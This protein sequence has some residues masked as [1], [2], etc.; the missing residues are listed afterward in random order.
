MID[1]NFRSRWVAVAV[2]SLLGACAA[3]APKP[4]PEPVKVTPQQPKAEPTPDPAKDYPSVFTPPSREDRTA[5]IER[6]F[7]REKQ[8]KAVHLSLVN[9]MLNQKNHYAALAHLDAYDSKWGADVNSKRLR[10]DALRK[11]G[12]LDEAERIYKQLLGK[13]DGGLVWYGL[14]RVS[15]DRG[16]LN[17]A[18]D[19]L[20]KSVKEDPLLTDAYSDLGLTYMLLNMQQSSYDAL[21]RAVQLSKNEPKSVANL[22]M[23]AIVNERYE[24]A[25]DLADRLEWS[26]I[27][28]SKMMA[29]A[30]QIRQKYVQQ[31]GESR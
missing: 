23:W 25:N 19:R 1:R 31:T 18:K 3:P 26:D 24:M 7:Q 2:V 30:S 10:A 6:Q 14:G 21:M 12:Q 9:R 22:A 11:T 29:Q 20:E 16:D 28:R 4:A 27:T 5:E 17:N 13:L 8:E 15:I